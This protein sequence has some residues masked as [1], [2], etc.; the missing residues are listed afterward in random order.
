MNLI[1]LGRT[2]W[3]INKYNIIS[4]KIQDNDYK[5]AQWIQENW[6]K[7]WE[8]KQRVINLKEEPKLKNT[9]IEIKI[10]KKQ[11]AVD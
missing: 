7:Q 3:S 4:I 9:L 11:S 6:W 8:V 10:H 1:K 2:K 5:D